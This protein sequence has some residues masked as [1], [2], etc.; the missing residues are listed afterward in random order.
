MLFHTAHNLARADPMMQAPIEHR[1]LSA[2]RFQCSATTHP[3]A[4]RL[5]NEDSYVNRPD[6]GLWAVADGAGGHQAG[7]VAS[8]IIAD[9]LN[10]VSTG[11]DGAELLAEVRHCLA[12]AHNA[13]LREAAR[14]GPQAMIVS[15]I[16]AL[17]LRD[18]YYA[19]LW[20]GDSRAYLLRGQRFRQLT[21]DHSLVQELFDAG[22]ISAAEALHHP[23]ANIITRAI[24]AEGL[25]LDKV[26]DRLFPGDRFLLCTDGLFKALPE[27]ELAELLAADED[28]IADRLV[29]AG[30]REGAADNLTAV[31][32][33]V[34]L[35]DRAGAMWAEPR[36]L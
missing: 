35:D 19:C 3:G 27:R 31:T 20:A 9:A 30:L 32:V 10:S 26:T 7:E 25:E 36:H 15:T 21:R 8:R 16:V 33:E 12:R 22:A 24:G 1:A 11:I 17:L 5:H 6:L 29:V 14:R 2:W 34:T 23:S 28:I 13:L 4:V 18:D